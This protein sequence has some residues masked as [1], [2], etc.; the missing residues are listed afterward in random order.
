ME[1]RALEQVLA[2]FRDQPVAHL[3][4]PQ[5]LRKSLA[6]SVDERR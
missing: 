1:T 6:G 2:F 3:V 5:V 4:N